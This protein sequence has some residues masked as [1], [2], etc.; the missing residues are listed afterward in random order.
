VQKVLC[1]SISY[2]PTSGMLL[3]IPLGTAIAK[4]SFVI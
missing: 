3:L 4:H 1:Y 2:I